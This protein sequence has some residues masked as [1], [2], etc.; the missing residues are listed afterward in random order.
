MPKL[1][2]FKP[3]PPV[4]KGKY[5]FVVLPLFIYVASDN[6][7]QTVVDN[8]N[9]I[10]S[11]LALLYIKSGFWHTLRGLELYGPIHVISYFMGSSKHFLTAL[12]IV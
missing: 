9:T 2:I 8:L 6:N 1:E 3:P 5:N 11:E 10:L 7:I 12:L 4:L